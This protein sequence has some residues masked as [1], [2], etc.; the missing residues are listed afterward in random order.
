[1][2]RR[3]I[4]ALALTCVLMEAVGCNTVEGMGHDIS[5]LGHALSEAA[6]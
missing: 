1:M 5:D 6:N 3:I 2:I 4:L